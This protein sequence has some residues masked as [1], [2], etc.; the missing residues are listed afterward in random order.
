MTIDVVVPFE[1]PAPLASPSILHTQAV[2]ADSHAVLVDNGKARAS[3][4]LCAIGDALQEYS[5]IGSSSLHARPR[6][7][8]PIEAAELDEV[9]ANAHIVIT[10]VGDC[11]GCTAGTVTDGIRCLGRGVPTVVLVTTPF[12]ALART[13]M[14]EYDKSG[15]QLLVVEH[16]I[17][18]RDASWF[19]AT[20]RTLAQE[21]R[22]ALP[23][24]SLSL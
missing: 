6:G 1:L 17:W 21:I 3:Q 4:L 12:E 5:V 19:E 7:H 18:T 11:G 20:G 16:P 2:A 24:A 13:V 8:M 22:A 10:G 15:I 9:V 14:A 23:Q